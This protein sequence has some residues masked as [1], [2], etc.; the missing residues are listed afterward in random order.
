MNIKI[1]IVFELIPQR[2]EVSKKKPLFFIYISLTE[3]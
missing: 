3:N 2:R 1:M